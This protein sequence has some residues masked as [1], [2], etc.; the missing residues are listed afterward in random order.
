MRITK[1][2]HI[3]LDR[4]STNKARRAHPAAAILHPSTALSKVDYACPLDTGSS[5]SAGC[6]S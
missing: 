2:A 6:W 1:P 5:I 4:A 3:S